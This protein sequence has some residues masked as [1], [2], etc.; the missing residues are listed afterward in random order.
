[1]RNVI[2]AMALS[3]VNLVAFAQD[4]AQKFAATITGDD[5]KKHLTIVASAEMEG[6][7]TG[8][9]GQRKAASYIETQFKALGLQAPSSLN[10]YQ[11][12]YQVF[13]DSFL[14]SS[15]SKY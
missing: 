10:G 2:A 14:F 12:T 6:R 15:S 9:E 13:K 4:D 5:L 8:T 7:E 1:M 11:Q 3:L